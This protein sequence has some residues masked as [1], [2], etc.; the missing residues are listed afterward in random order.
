MKSAYILEVETSSAFQECTPDTS[1]QNDGMDSETEE[2]RA[3]DVKNEKQ[4]DNE[5]GEE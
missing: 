1:K 2:T 5:K 4:N 3:S